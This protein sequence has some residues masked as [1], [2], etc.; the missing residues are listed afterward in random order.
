MVD[1]ILSVGGL[2]T[3]FGLSGATGLNAYLPLLVTGILTKVDYI[4]LDDRYD[5]LAGWPVIAVVAALFIVDFIGDKIP[6]IDHI[7]HA[8]GTII[9]PIAGALAF[10]SQTGAVTKMNPI[11]SLVLGATTGGGLHLARAAVRPMSTIGT[12]GV[13]NPIMSFG[14]DLTAGLLTALA[15]IIPIL[16]AVALVLVVWFVWRLWRRAGRALAPGSARRA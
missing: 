8:V 14:E 6:A 1:D 13:G 4:Q 7:F 3:A 11:L 12:A 15:F 16:V 5:A 10:A 9:H 2:L